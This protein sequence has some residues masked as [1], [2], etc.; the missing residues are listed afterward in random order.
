[1]YGANELYEAGQQVFK[2]LDY[3]REDAMRDQE[4]Q[5]TQEHGRPLRTAE[6]QAIRTA[7]LDAQRR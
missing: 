2:V 6:R 1:M 3:I 5:E 7:R 4:R